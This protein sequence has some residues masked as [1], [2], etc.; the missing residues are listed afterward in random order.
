MFFDEDLG[1]KMSK[2]AAFFKLSSPSTKRVLIGT[3]LTNFLIIAHNMT[4]RYYVYLGDPGRWFLRETRGR[5]AVP[6]AEA[7]GLSLG[8]ECVAKYELPPEVRN[9]HY[10][11]NHGLVY[12]MGQN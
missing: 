6:E 2:L 10:G 4:S 8:P 3:Y 1:L 7:G 11:L 9:D 5:P 12:E